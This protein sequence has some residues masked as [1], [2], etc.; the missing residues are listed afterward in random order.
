MEPH[1]I[2]EILAHRSGH[3]RGPAGIYNR[4]AYANQVRTALLMWSDHIHALVKGG[5]RKVVPL[6][7]V[8]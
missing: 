4:S 8:P 5:E 7:Q 1:I 3:K 2:E 6:R